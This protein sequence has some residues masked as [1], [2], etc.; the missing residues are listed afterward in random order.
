MEKIYHGTLVGGHPALD[1]V[2][3]VSDS[4]KT[5]ERSRISDWDHFQSWAHASDIFPKGQ[6]KQLN[7]VS[8]LS[9][10][11]SLLEEF[12]HLREMTYSILSSIA[13]GGTPSTEQQVFIENHIKMAINYAEL[14]YREDRYEWTIA[15]DH[16][17]WLIGTLALSIEN[18]IRSQEFRKLRECGRCTWLF[19][20]KGR[21]KGRK[22]CDMRKCGNRSKSESFR[23]RQK[24]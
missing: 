24:Q 10:S 1:F 4:G 5:R 21:G 9:N 20:D 23:D 2:N 12:H 3:T 18:L 8:G 14:G 16:S 11:T 17:D 15:V 7:A 6:L 13:S 22:W 19:L